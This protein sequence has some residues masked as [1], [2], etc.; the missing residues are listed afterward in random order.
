[1][2]L[3]GIDADQDCH[4]GELVNDCLLAGTTFNRCQAE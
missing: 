3:V 4:F 2:R 1:M